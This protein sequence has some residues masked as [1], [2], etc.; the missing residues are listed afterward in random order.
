MPSTY[1]AAKNGAAMDSLEKDIATGDEVWAAYSATYM[2]PEE[3]ATIDAAAN[4]E[5]AL[6]RRA[7]PRSPGSAAGQRPQEEANAGES[8]GGSAPN[9]P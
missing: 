5:T 2:T 1:Q 3:K 9:Q 6:D 8:A 7:R 4:H